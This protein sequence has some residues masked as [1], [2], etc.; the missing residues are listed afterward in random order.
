MIWTRFKALFLKPR[1]AW[2]GN[3]PPSTARLN[4][5]YAEID[6]EQ[7]RQGDIFPGAAFSPRTLPSMD[8]PYWMLINRT[9]HLYEDRERKLKLSHLNYAAVYPLHNFVVNGPSAPKLKKQISSIIKNNEGVIF[10]PAWKD[11]QIET[12]LV[13]N[14]NLLFTVPAD[15]APAASAKKLQLASPF[16]EHAFQKFSRYFYTVGYDDSHFRSDT[17][18]ESLADQT[19]T[20]LGS[21]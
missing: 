3:H 2:A 21:K 10:L 13:A 16:C 14:F 20:L 5:C 18:I 4:E 6:R 8:V 11:G 19:E 12:P 1:S 15:G 17:Y 7:R 9:C